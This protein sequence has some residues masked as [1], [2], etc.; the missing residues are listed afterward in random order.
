MNSIFQEQNQDLILIYELILLQ[1]I[2]YIDF[3][4]EI[5]SDVAYGNVGFKITELPEFRKN[6]EEI[7]V[8]KINELLLY[9][10]YETKK[11]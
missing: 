6:C 5:I 3:Q 2:D 10:D 7:P 11:K 4:P 9:S 1:Q 8:Q